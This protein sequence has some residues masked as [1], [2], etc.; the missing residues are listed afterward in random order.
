MVYAWLAR[1]VALTNHTN[2]PYEN[3]LLMRKSG[4]IFSLF[5]PVFQLH[6]VSCNEMHDADDRYNA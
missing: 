5:S 4:V 2:N 1:L 3:D 6:C